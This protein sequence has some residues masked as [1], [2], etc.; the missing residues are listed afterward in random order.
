MTPFIE[1]IVLI[2]GVSVAKVRAY[3]LSEISLA[4]DS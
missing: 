1:L 4:K 2:I 3:K